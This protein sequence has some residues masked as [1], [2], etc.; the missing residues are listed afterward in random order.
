MAHLDDWAG[1]VA[2]TFFVLVIYQ[3][4]IYPAVF[5]P[6]ARIPKAQWSVPFSRIWILWVRYVHRENRT[7]HSAHRRLGPILRIGPNEL[8]ISDLDSVRTVYQG[9]F[10]K[11]VWYSVFDNYG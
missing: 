6:L 3:Y 9:G 4:I 1:A 11:P 10:G 8:S 2:L 7:L 5:S